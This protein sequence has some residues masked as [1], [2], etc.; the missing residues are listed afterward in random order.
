MRRSVVSFRLAADA[1]AQ[2]EDG[3]CTV[4]DCKLQ[5]A[6]PFLACPRH[7]RLNSTP[8]FMQVPQDKYFGMLQRLLE[9]ANRVCAC[10]AAIFIIYSEFEGSLATKRMLMGVTSAPTLSNT[11]SSPLAV[12]FLTALLANTTVVHAAIDTLAQ[13]QGANTSNSTVVY[14]DGDPPSVSF[15]AMCSQSSTADFLYDPTVLLPLLGHILAP[16]SLLQNAPL[17]F[18]DC[19]YDGRILP[20]TTTLKVFLVDPSL[21]TLTTLFVQTLTISRPA[22]HRESSGGL[23]T[24]TSTSLASCILDIYAPAGVVCSDDATYTMTVGLECPYEADDFVLVNMSLTPSSSGAWPAHIVSTGEDIILIA[25]EGIYR[26]APDVR[27]SYDW[28][29]WNLSSD[30]VAF[31]AETTYIT[32]FHIKDSWGFFRCFLGLGIAF[33]LLMTG[34][35]SLVVM[36]NLYRHKRVLWL[37]DLYPTIQR[38]AALR[39]VLLVADC[40]FNRWWYPFQYAFN[41]AK[42]RA[43]YGGGMFLFEM[44]RADGLMVCLAITQALAASLRVRVQLHVTVVLFVVCFQRRDQLIDC[45]NFLAAAT[46]EY[47][48]ASYMAQIV[49]DNSVEDAMSVWAWI[50]ADETN[51]TLM[52]HEYAW[53]F[54]A[55]VVNVGYVLVG[56]LAT[57]SVGHVAAFARRRSQVAAEPEQRFSVM[58]PASVAMGD[59]HWSKRSLLYEPCTPA[60][61]DATCVE[62]SVGIIAS[63]V[64]GF[65]STT[66]QY[67]LVESNQARHLRRPSAITQELSRSGVWLLGYVILADKY[68]VA[69]N[70]VPLVVLNVLWRRNLFEIYAFLLDG[71]EGDGED[72]GGASGGSDDNA[73]TTTTPRQVVLEKVRLKYSD[74]ASPRDLVRITLDQLP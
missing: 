66:P 34:L 48:T 38:R 23:A 10:L 8:T 55:I 57:M 46:S 51:F 56:K 27:C 21:T 44:V 39:V 15:N 29:W 3:E 62:R 26:S 63:H 24:F 64:Y 73:T 60:D 68:L 13:L 54:V 53:L 65:V 36:A 22:I 67:A 31:I 5:T 47:V 28:F 52:V 2:N 18:V 72:D 9:H 70:D 20:D 6:S 74:L 7:C 49:T 71:G 19:F 11:Y 45:T 12:S 43:G 58:F 42:L 30:P 4:N 69:V 25:T 17:V 50:E 33:N 35:V 1:L 41:E 37:P 16:T 32:I 61:I 40:L 59:H 14:I